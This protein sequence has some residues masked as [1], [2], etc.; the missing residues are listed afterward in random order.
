MAKSEI[1]VFII[2]VSLAILLLVSGIIVFIIMYRKRKIIHD[3]EKAELEKLH[4][5]D[6]LST[7]LESQWQTMQHIGREIHDNVGQKLTLASIYAKQSEGKDSVQQGY[8]LKEI[9]IIIDESLSELRQLSKSLTNP[10]AMQASLGELLSEEAKRIN[11]AGV[12]FVSLSGNE[13][14]AIFPPAEKNIFFRILQE[15][16]QN[17]LKHADCRRVNIAIELDGQE[18]HIT[19]SDDGKGFDTTLTSSGIGLQNMERR[20]AQVN[21]ELKLTSTP[22]EGTS[23][24]IKWKP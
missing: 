23:L 19:A 4:Q 12:I 2:L 15:F 1:V 17:S 22:G 7:R 9:G 20:S 10:D 18:F 3:I 5:L 21:A 24:L 8:K 6:L 11:A 16:M 14:N 13:V